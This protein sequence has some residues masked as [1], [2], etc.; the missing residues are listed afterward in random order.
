DHAEP[1][2]VRADG[3]RLAHQSAMPDVARQQGVG[4]LF[5]LNST[6]GTTGMPKCV[7]HN[8]N[9][10]LYYHRQVMQSGSFSGDDVFLSLIPAPFG[11]GLWTAHFTPIILGCT[12]VVMS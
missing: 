2:H 6:S 8:Q 7:V 11:F 1:R 5:M 10:W 9:R 3:Q 4:D 12:T